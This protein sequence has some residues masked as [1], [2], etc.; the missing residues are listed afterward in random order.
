MLLP[1]GVPVSPMSLGQYT[2]E[3]NLGR[4]D[5]VLVFHRKISQN[6]EIAGVCKKKQQPSKRVN[7]FPV[8]MII[9]I[10]EREF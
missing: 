9:E 6:W 4:N 3:G 7:D 2:T 1:E 8:F 10:R 5:R